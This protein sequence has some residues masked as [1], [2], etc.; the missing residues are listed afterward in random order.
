MFDLPDDD[1]RV[2]RI[3]REGIEGEGGYSIFDMESWASQ[4]HCM[5]FQTGTRT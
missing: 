2:M 3:E 1:L 5:A 4:P